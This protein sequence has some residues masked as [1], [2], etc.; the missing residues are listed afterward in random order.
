MDTSTQ[1]TTNYSSNK[2]KLTEWIAWIQKNLD[3]L[4]TAWSDL[5]NDSS[6]SIK[7]KWI[8]IQWSYHELLADL[9]SKTDVWNSEVK[10]LEHT[11][12]SLSAKAKEL[13]IDLGSEIKEELNS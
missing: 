13:W 6:T 7:E 12:K 11:L 1:E 10:E 2:I 4:T 9:Y 3:I 8:E 5:L